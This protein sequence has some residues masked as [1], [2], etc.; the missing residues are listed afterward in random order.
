MRKPHRSSTSSNNK[1]WAIRSIALFA[2]A[3]LLLSAIF[4]LTSVQT[5]SGSTTGT[6]LRAASAINGGGVD[7]GSLPVTIPAAA[8]APKPDSSAPKPPAANLSSPN[9]PNSPNTV[10][11]T[12]TKRDGL[13][14]DVNGNGLANP[15]DTISYAVGITDTGST[16][17]T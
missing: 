5:P 17:A 3:L 1:V 14:V 12:A 8:A 11:I 13:A 4:R 10:V 15:G 16:D 9:S 2:L 7:V 6:E